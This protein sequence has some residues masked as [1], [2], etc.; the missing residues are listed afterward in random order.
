YRLP[1]TAT[2][3][4]NDYTEL[5][6]HAEFLGVMTAQ[7]IL[8]RWFVHDSAKTQDWR[9]QGLAVKAF[10]VWVSS[11]AACVSKP[12]DLGYSDEG[13]ILPPLNIQTHQIDTDLVV[14]NEDGLLFDVSKFGN[15]SSMDLHKW[16]RKS[17]SERS[18]M[19]SSMVNGTSDPW[20]V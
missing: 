11:W 1:C 13:Y 18:R 20:I 17:V 15:V 7:E 2:P 6:N 8:T 19:V 10:W 16:K 12:S 14:N 3:A 9:L 5:G 4:P